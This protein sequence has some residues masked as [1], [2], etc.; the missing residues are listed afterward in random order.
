MTQ[1]LYTMHVYRCIYVAG[2]LPVARSPGDQK[3]GG[4]QS[5]WSSLSRRFA[6]CSDIFFYFFANLL[7]KDGTEELR[8]GGIFSTGLPVPLAKTSIASGWPGFALDTCRLWSTVV[9]LLFGLVC[10]RQRSCTPGSWTRMQE[11]R[12]RSVVLQLLTTQPIYD[13]SMWATVVGLLLTSRHCRSLV[14]DL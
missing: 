11:G 12:L 4:K 10:F 14:G 8:H 1:R 7:L 5:S 6:A 13:R 3:R 2:S 9:V